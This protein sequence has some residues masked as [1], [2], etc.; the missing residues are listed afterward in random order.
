MIPLNKVA[1]AA[2]FALSVAGFSGCETPYGVT[3][4]VQYNNPAWA[5]PYHHGCRYYYFPDIETYY[6]MSM[7]QFVYLHNGQWLFMPALPTIYSH[8]DLYTGFIITL[9]ISVYQ[10]WMHHQYYVAHYPRYYYHNVYINER[11][12]IRGFNENNRKPF[13]WQPGEKDRIKDIR[14]NPPHGQPPQAQHQP[15]NTNYYGKPVGKPVKVKPQ[16]KTKEKEK[17]PQ[18]KRPPRN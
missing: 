1:L 6:D 15:Q 4:T 2:A 5:P 7:E 10:P 13:Y 17:Q 18:V 11:D 16:M 3:T 12:R 14:N 9:N 8:F